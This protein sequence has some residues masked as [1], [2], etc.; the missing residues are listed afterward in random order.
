[1]KRPLEKR[2]TGKM[3]VIQVSEKAGEIRSRTQIRSISYIITGMKVTTR[4]NRISFTDLLN[5]GL[6]S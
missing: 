4:V 3:A 1:M 5:G 6:D 2:L